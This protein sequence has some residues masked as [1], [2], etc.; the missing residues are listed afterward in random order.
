MDP[1]EFGARKIIVSAELS[2]RSA[3]PLRQ[4]PLRP[5][6]LP[7]LRKLRK[8]PEQLAQIKFKMTLPQ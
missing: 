4:D 2:R 3:E 8:A 1:E 7:F 6:W 5:R